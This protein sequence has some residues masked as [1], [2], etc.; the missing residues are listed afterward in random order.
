MEIRVAGDNVRVQKSALARKYKR[1]IYIY[2]V[3][4]TEGRISS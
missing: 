1:H 3:Y 2:I 4:N